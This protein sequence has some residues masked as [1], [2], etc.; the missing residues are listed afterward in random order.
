M[1][2][3]LSTYSIPLEWDKNKY[4]FS[5]RS[6]VLVKIPV[7]LWEGLIKGKGFS[8][9][10]LSSNPL[11]EKLHKTYILASEDEDEQ[12]YNKLK[13]DYLS[14]SFQN[15]HLSLTILPTQTC[16]LC[17]P[18]C[19]EGEKTKASMTESVQDALI[20]FITTRS[21]KTYSITWF[22]GE[23][24]LGPDI[25]ESILEK[26]LEHPEIKCTY[27]SIVTNGT[28][29]NN[30]AEKLFTRF[31]LNSIQI[32]LDG[33]KNKHDLVRYD[34]KGNGTFEIIKENIITFAKRFP[35]THIS[36]RVNVSKDNMADFYDVYAGV[37]EWFKSNRITN[38]H[39]YPGIIKMVEG[40]FVS[41]TCLN[42]AEQQDF[43]LKLSQKGMNFF[44][45]PKNKMG[46]CTATTSMSM[47]VGAKGDIFK[48]WEDVG[49]DNLMVGSLMNKDYYNDTL[50]SDYLLKGSKFAS[51]ECR[52][53]GYLPICS[54]GCPKERIG[55]NS[56]RP[57]QCTLYSIN[58]GR[59]LKTVLKDKL[60][61]EDR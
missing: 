5:S 26:L 39:V 18:Y 56:V 13:I 61:P 29:L 49:K 3:R 37:A 12:Y 41:S 6:K 50:L 59:L 32:T 53:C 36:I 14:S 52:R 47:V 45:Y 60:K 30:Q 16:N 22:G 20:R 19:F 11:I 35:S 31:P 55:G 54:G 27:H 9:E 15:S 58:E 10:A 43:Y 23:P 48:C 1:N 28:L 7:L 40:G 21:I 2:Y 4:V 57:N 24:L 8:M 44:G 34:A 51:E 33:K 42:R 46:G 17:C 25:I 38:Y